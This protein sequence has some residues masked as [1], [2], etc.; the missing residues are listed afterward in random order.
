MNVLLSV[1]PKYVEEIISGRKKYEFRKSI[2][3]REDI[4]KLYIYSS[5]P[6]KKIIAIV[7]ID[8]IISDSPQELWEQCHEDAGI[9]EREFFRYFKNSDVGYAIKISNVQEFSTPVDPYNIN[10]DFRPPQ[11]FYYPSI[12]FVQNFWNYQNT[13]MNK[14]NCILAEPSSGYSCTK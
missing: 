3:K 7:D 11:S 8:G 2:F 1:K 12:N 13:N 5:S 9:S 10:E 6:V 14:G 4:K